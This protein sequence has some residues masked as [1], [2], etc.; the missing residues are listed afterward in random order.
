MG[1]VGLGGGAV[2]PVRMMC[3]LRRMEW[4]RAWSF[5]RERGSSGGD[6]W[7]IAM[8]GV[9]CF[10]CLLYVSGDLCA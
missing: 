8:D 10:F 5:G 2:G 9:G 4:V 3:V 6:A 7:N 1:E